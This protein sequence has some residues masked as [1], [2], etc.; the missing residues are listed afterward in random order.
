MPQVTWVNGRLINP[1]KP[2]FG[3][4]ERGFLYGEGLYETIRVSDCRPLYWKEHRARLAHGCTV[5]KIPLQQNEIDTGVRETAQLLANGVLRLTVTRGEI[6]GRGL[7]PARDGAPTALIT[8]YTGEPYPEQL[9]AK[10]FKAC[11]ISFPRSHRS[12]LVKLKTTSCLEMICAKMEANAAG[13]DEGLFMNYC[14]AI[15]EG[16]TSNVFL[17]I[18]NKL[19]TPPPECG[20]LPGIMRAQVLFLAEKLGLSAAQEKIFPPDFARAEESFLTNALLGVMP[21]VSF[22]GNPVGNGRPGKLAK[23]LRRKLQNV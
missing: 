18:R 14:G 23:I 16:T 21:L 6:P 10:G 7:V 11:L 19:I 8:G 3:V 20:L 5:L 12:P 22:E 15:T 2:V 13:A 17:V 9:Y 4:R 1:Q